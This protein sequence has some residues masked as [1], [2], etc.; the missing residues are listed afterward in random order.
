[1]RDKSYPTITV[2]L[3]TISRPT[4]ARSLD[5]LTRQSWLPGDELLLIGDG[6]QPEAS[7]LFTERNLPGRYIEI[8]EGPLGSWGH[9]ARNWVLGRR[10]PSC[11]VICA[12]DDDDTLEVNHFKT[13]RVAAAAYVGKCVLFRMRREDGTVLWTDRE[14]RVGNVGTPMFIV[15][16][17][18]VWGRYG[19]NHNG[20]SQFIYQTVTLRDE[21]PVWRED[22]IYN[23]GF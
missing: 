17:D 11:D 10:L 1:M 14:I 7:R 22:V 2:V 8:T 18:G 5:S 23:V 9:G 6:P 15:P 3:P 12:L 19:E 4:L 13:V 16:N 20:D 21:Q